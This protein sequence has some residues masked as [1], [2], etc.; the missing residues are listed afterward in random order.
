MGR[1]TAGGRQEDGRCRGPGAQGC[2][3]CAWVSGV[4]TVGRKTASVEVRTSWRKTGPARR[5]GGV[6]VSGPRGGIGGT[7]VW[8]PGHGGVGGQRTGWGE[9]GDDVGLEDGGRR[10]GRGRRGP[11]CDE[12][13]P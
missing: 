4:R 8:A 5:T 7:V 10:R 9:A 3:G 1:K 12:A 13:R 2:Q 6:G 11:R